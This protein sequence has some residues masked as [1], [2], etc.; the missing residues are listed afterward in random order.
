MK[1][2]LAEDERASGRLARMAHV[3]QSLDGLLGLPDRGRAP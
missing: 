1:E 3:V 2:A